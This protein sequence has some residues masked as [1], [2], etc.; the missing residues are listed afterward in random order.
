MKDG[1]AEELK[2]DIPMDYYGQSE[3]VA[4]T[5]FV[6]DLLNKYFSSVPNIELIISDNQKPKATIIK[7]AG[8]EE[9]FIHIFE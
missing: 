1:K 7:E 5:Q 2:I 4:L 3:V 8:E 6:G 9:P